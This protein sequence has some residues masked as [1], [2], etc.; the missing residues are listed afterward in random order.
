MKFLE[1]EWREKFFENKAWFL[2]CR[3]I[4]CDFQLKHEIVSHLY[5]LYHI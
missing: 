3:K 1:E 5:I 4:K 2:W